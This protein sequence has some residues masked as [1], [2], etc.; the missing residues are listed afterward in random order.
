MELWN[1]ELVQKT[2]AELYKRAAVDEAF[3]N[4]CLQNPREAVRQIAGQDLPEG[5]NLRFVD[6][7]GA[8]LTLVLPDLR[9]GEDLDDEQ[10]DMVAGG[11]AGGTSLI[12][13]GKGCVASNEDFGNSCA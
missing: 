10:L 9:Q 6:N 1:S 7:G 12:T 2:W 5:F 3:R 8:D 11:M 13:G 4:L